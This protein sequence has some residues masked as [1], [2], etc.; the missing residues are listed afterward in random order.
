MPK[1][2]EEFIREISHALGLLAPTVKTNRS[3]VSVTDIAAF[4]RGAELW[5]HPQFVARYHADDFPEL[6]ESER[7][8]LS[9]AIGEFRIVTAAVSPRGPATS[10]QSRAGRKHLDKICAILKPTLVAFWQPDVSG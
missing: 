1:R 2:K 5:L 8:E 3:N 7:E 10:D 6:T 9:N 4:M